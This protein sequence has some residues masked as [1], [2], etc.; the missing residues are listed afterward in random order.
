MSNK[1]SKRSMYV[2]KSQWDKYAGTDFKP[3]TMVFTAWQAL[4][5]RTPSYNL[6]FKLD[7]NTASALAKSLAFFFVMDDYGANLWLKLER[8]MRI[9]KKALDEACALAW[10]KD[11]EQW[12]AEE[13]DRFIN[14]CKEIDDYEKENLA[15][16]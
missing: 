4:A 13:Q 11:Y 8:Q 7:G 15:R 5:T 2:P 14:I 16:L 3:L 9:M 1:Y 10:G 12:S 6:D